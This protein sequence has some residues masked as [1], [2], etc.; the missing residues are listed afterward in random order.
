MKRRAIKWKSVDFPEEIDPLIPKITV[1][2]QS[3]MLLENH[4]GILQY[5]EDSVRI[6]TGKG[7]LCVSGKELKLSELGSDRVYI[8]GKLI[9]WQYED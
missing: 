9:S 8:R 5:A 3:D 7:C 4:M 6:M 1:L 2:A